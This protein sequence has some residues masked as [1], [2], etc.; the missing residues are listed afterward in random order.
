MTSVRQFFGNEGALSKLVK[1]YAVREPQLD[2]AESI[3]L[4]IKDKK[5]LVAEA[6]TGTGKTFAYLVPAILSNKKTIISTGTK[7]LQEQLFSRDLPMVKKAIDKTRKT[8]LLKGRANYLCIHRLSLNGGD[9]MRLDRQTLSE[10][11]LIKKWSLKTKT[12]D[13]G[14]VSTLKEGASVIPLVTSSVDNC[15]GKD[16][17]VYED[18]YLIK[19]RQQ[20]MKADVV[21][22][23]HHLFFADLALKEDGFGELIPQAETIVFDEAHLLPDIASEYFGKSFS[24]RQMNDLLIDIEKTQKVGLKDADQ[25]SKISLKAQQALSDLRL[26]FAV[27]PERGELDKVFAAKDFNQRLERV[28]VIVEQL[29]AAADVHEGRDKDLDRYFER[30]AEM[31]SKLLTITNKQQADVS[32]WYETTKRHLIFHMTPLNISKQFSEIVSKSDT[33]WIF[34][35]ATISVGS[36]FSHYQQSMGLNH[37]V[38]VQLSSPFDYQQQALLCVPRYLPAPSSR[39]MQQHL[40]DISYKLIEAS[41]G[42]VFLLFTSHFMM[43]SVAKGVVDKYD[44]EVLVQG[45]ASKQALLDKFVK[46][47]DLPLFATGAFWEGVDVKGEA[48]QCVLIDKLPFAA[49]DDPLLKARIKDC[50]DAGGNPFVDIQIPQAVIALKQGAGRLIR[51]DND[52]GVLVICD[53]RLVNKHYASTFLESVPA[54][55]RTRDLNKVASFLQSLSSSSEVNQ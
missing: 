55:S 30:L 9:H 12:G 14:E 8:A 36:D 4:A 42:R 31:Q 15:L 16:C 7:N 21:V 53:N 11:Q 49:P 44:I 52:R 23:N 38:T 27:D 37:A 41:K 28:E 33:S 3:E 5:T 47:R 10:Y 19:A 17:K 25:L 40:I 43:R 26:H 45:D 2:L 34:T 6:G 20:A 29:L 24:T 46:K 39:D 32:L 22:V 50:R 48:L 1:G 51:D 18:C 54:M 13:L 35:S